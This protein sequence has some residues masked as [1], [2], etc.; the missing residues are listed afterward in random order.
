MR[1][2]APQYSF[3][4]PRRQRFSLPHPL[5][6]YLLETES[7]HLLQKLHQ[8]C[9]YFFAKKKILVAADAI[10]DFGSPN[11]NPVLRCNNF[12]LPLTPTTR[13][14]VTDLYCCRKDSYSILR[15]YIYRATLS[16]LH[17]LY[18]NLSLNDIDFL[19]NNKMQK[20]IL[21]RVDIH[22][23]DGN[24]VPID[25]I[26]GKVPEVTEFGYHNK[27][28]IY[29]NQSL[30][31]LNFITLKKK[32]SLLSLSMSQTSEEIDAEILGTFVE[33]HLASNGQLY[34][35]FGPNAPEIEAV[36]TKV[37]QVLKNWQSHD[38]GPK[39]SVGTIYFN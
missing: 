4:S 29:S 17:I 34:L 12:E 9:K 30:S 14:W 27:C 13:Y 15:P 38:G 22:D 5:I 35:L 16:Q 10:S 6:L 39:Y 26:L 20:L 31:K 2:P 19:L 23:V 32:L 28:E 21:Y 8:A 24:P 7:P 11:W 33:S 1:L 18:Q 36:K 37:Q 25:Y 3:N